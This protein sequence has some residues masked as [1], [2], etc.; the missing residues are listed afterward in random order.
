MDLDYVR[1]AIDSLQDFPGRIGL[2]G[3]DQFASKI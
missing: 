3:G 2:M 1:K